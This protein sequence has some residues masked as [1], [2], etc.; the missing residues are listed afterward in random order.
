MMITRIDHGKYVNW[1]TIKYFQLI[2]ELIK[3]EKCQKKYD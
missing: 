1:A 3:W 2:K